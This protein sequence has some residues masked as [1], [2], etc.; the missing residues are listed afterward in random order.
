MAVLME[1]SIPVHSRATRSSIPALALISVATS[2]GLAP[3]WITSV[4]TPG[5]RVSANLRRDSN[6]SVMTIG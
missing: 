1:L 5:T 4:L 6:R 2:S 3:R